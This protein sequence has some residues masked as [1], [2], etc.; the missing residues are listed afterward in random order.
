MQYSTRIRGIRAA[1]VFSGLL[2]GVAG[3]HHK[4]VVP[5]LPQITQP[6][7]L[8]T[9]PPSENPPLVEAQPVKLPPVP[10]A[11][12]ATKIKRERKK[13]PAQP[14]TTAAVTPPPGPDAA[15]A[16]A[17]VTPIGTLSSGGD[18]SPRAQQEAASLITAN[19]KR[20]NGLSTQKVEEEKAQLSKVRNFQRQAQEALNSGD[21]E[22]AKTLATKAKLLLDDIEKL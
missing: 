10:T 4:P 22:G 6:V 21:T 9:P 17:E 13:K 1:V 20:I 8:A 14:T 18:T 12:A 19:E 16:P 3:C 15:T 5:P 11:S 2:L 7:D